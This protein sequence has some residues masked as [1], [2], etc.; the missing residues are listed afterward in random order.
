MRKNLLLFI[1]LSSL[2]AF[3]NVDQIKTALSGISNCTNFLKVDSD[4]VY[5][6]YGYYSNSSGGYHTKKPTPLTIIPVNQPDNK[7]EIQISDSA[8]DLIS[9]GNSLWVLTYTGL[10]EWD[11]SNW[12]RIAVY[13]TYP[14]NENYGFEENA[15]QMVEYKE[16]LIISYGRLG[17]SIFDLNSR[18]V[19]H[20][21]KLMQNLLPLESKVTGV[22]VIGDK[23]YFALDSFTLVQEP[24]AEK[25]FQGIIVYDLINSKILHKLDGMEPGSDNLFSY[26]NK[27]V[28]SFYGIPLFRYD[29]E[30]LTGSKLPGPTYRISRFPE[31]GRLLGKPTLDKDYIYTCF[32]K[33]PMEDGAKIERV[34]RVWP[35]KDL[36]LD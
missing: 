13:E 36:K 10:E 11:K 29:A 16:K 15:T 21:E 24:S 20:H 18:K 27:L 26:D 34:P 31:T 25:P 1:I 19:V 8:I 23:A 3:A 7:I 17:F 14:N 6:G 30:K 2:S 9:K 33:M 32:Q 12:N 22:A 35:R 5:L 28:I 4:N